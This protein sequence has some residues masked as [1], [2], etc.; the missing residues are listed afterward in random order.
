M[1]LKPFTD[2]GQGNLY[3][4]SAAEVISPPRTMDQPVEI[5]DGSIQKVLNLA[6]V[7]EP[8][9]ASIVEILNNRGLTLERTVDTLSETICSGDDGIKLRSAEM[10]FKLHGVLKDNVQEMQI[11][12][13]IEGDKQNILIPRQ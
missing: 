4:D 1:I 11:N 9:K 3:Y 6:G 8:K 5:P 13:L 7:K 2:E 12:F 10:S